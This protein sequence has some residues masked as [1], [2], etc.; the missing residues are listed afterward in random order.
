MGQTL[1]DTVYIEE[2]IKNHPRT[3]SILLRF[4]KARHILIERY[5]EVFNKRSQNFRLQKSSPA[6]ILAR[7]HSGHILSV[8]D[9][10]GIG[11]KKNFYFA[12]MSNCI[13][14]CRYCF[15]QGMFVSANYLL[16]INFE[17]FDEEMDKLIRE[18]PEDELTFFSGYDCDSLAFENI[19]GFVSHVLPF[20]EKHKSATLEL[21]TKSVQIRPLDLIT[22]IEN[23]VIA[24]S[25]MPSAMSKAL[26]HKAPS[27]ESRLVAMEKIA[28]MGWKI[29]L[30]FDPLIYGRNW[31]SHYQSLFEQVFSTVPK[32]SI[33]SV[34]YGPLRFPQS[35]F[36]KIFKL[37]PEEELFS[38]FLAP[39]NSVVAYTSEIEDTMANFCIEMLRNFVPDTIIFQCT[40]EV[41]VVGG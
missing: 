25:L 22:P 7:K 26:D 20:F 14:D 23:C 17:D 31:K 8:P 16:F 13:Y 37:Y 18:S 12:H 3:E 35:M 34:S 11:G 38:G 19:T 32:D 33:H 29:G 6:L 2:S 36:R 30:R 39:R 10:F 28:N 41:Q 4:G 40:P 1:I 24:Y 27:I 5:G 15:L 9:S 21:R